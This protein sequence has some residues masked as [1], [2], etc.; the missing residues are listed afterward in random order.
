[1]QI[2]LE[3]V[4][5]DTQAQKSQQGGTNC[6]FKLW[7]GDGREERERECMQSPSH[8]I[9]GMVIEKVCAIR[10][11]PEYSFAAVALK[12]WGKMHP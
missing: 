2:K 10:F 8:T 7:G 3:T 12:I 11:N 5:N 1:M 6:K 9:F 4:N